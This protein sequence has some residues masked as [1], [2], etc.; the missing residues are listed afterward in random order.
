MKGVIFTEFLEMVEEAFSPDMADQI[1]GLSQLSSDGAYTSLGNYSHLEI[2]QLVTQLSQQ[3]NI[4]VSE[5]V[6]EFGKRFINRFAMAHPEF[7]TEVDSAFA[8]LENVD[9]RVHV[10]VKKLYRNLSI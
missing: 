7:F 10:E 1:I 5:L 2:L 3:T 9:R 4:P 6:K 8:F